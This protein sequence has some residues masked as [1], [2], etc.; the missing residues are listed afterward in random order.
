[1]EYVNLGGSVK[2]CLGKELLKE[3]F[4]SGRLKWGGM[5]IEFIVGNMG[6]GLVLV[7]F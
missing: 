2:D 4:S 1:M 3:V 7:V 6:I 5:V